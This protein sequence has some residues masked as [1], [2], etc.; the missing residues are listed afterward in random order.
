[1]AS[2]VGQL[3]LHVAAGAGCWRCAALLHNAAPQAVAMKDRRDQTPAAI[4]AR[5]GHVVRIHLF[6]PCIVVYLGCRLLALRRAAAQRGAKGGGNKGCWDQMR[7]AIAAHR[8][9]LGWL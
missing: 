9:P 8:G 2:K 1:M 5:R 7:A 4:A 3:P 6:L